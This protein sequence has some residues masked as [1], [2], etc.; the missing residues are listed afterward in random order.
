MRSL[1]GDSSAEVKFGEYKYYTTSEAST[2]SLVDIHNWHDT[3]KK[4]RSE[5]LDLW[6]KRTVPG[7]TITRDADNREISIEGVSN[8]P[9]HAAQPEAPSASTSA[10]TAASE[11]TVV[12]ANSSHIFPGAGIQ[13]FFEWPFLD[14]EG[15]LDKRSRQD[16]VSLWLHRIRGTLQAKYT[17]MIHE[18]HARATEPEQVLPSEGA[19]NHGNERIHLCSYADVCARLEQPDTRKS[20]YITDMRR[21][22]AEAKLV[23]RLFVP[24]LSKPVSS[25]SSAQ[26]QTAQP[27]PENTGAKHG[28]AIEATELYWGA[29][30]TIILVIT[31]SDIA[32]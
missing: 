25:R 12:G 4:E 27:Y 28:P 17:A 10:E 14:D 1:G 18:G 32:P 16:K 30:A 5:K 7:L 19:V 9:D 31:P 2:E 24:V 11:T 8:S 20:R 26:S 3:L 13:P 22:H 15:K 23:F 6:I 21:L 29:L